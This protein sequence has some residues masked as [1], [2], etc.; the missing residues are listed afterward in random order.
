[1][2][3][4][5][6]QKGF[7]ESQNFTGFESEAQ[8]ASVMVIELPVPSGP[9]A[10]KRMEERFTPAALRSR[11]FVL[12]AKER[13]N[14]N[15]LPWLILKG[16]LQR[17]GNAYVQWLFLWESKD[18]HLAQVLVTAP[19]QNFPAVENDAKLM[20][21]SLRWETRADVAQ[22]GRYYS[23]T[24]P[25]GWKLAKQFGPVDLY[26]ESGRFPKGEDESALSVALLSERRVDFKRYVKEQNL[27]RNHYADLKELESQFLKI[28]GFDANISHV[29]GLAVEDHRP[30][31]LQYCYISLGAAT[32]FIEGERTA[33]LDQTLFESTCKTI[34]IKR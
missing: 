2:L 14:Q 34:K 26:T 27:K 11:G 4:L 7:T 25:K 18:P 29:S 13:G 31:I 10:L 6:P 5:V 23:I 24:L 3:S 32:M 8:E 1:M 17:E 28:D 19:A 33:K 9:G 16:E 30:V 22:A 21:E 20:L 12:K 15:G